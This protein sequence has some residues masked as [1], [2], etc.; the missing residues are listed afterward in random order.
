MGLLK[1]TGTLTLNQFWPSG[2]SDADTAHVAVKVAQNAFKFQ[3]HPGAPFKATHVFDKARVKGKFAPK[4]AIDKQGR[5]T[6]R[7]QGIDAPELH[8]SP[9][10]LTKKEKSQLTSAQLQQFKQLNKKYRQ[11]F[12]ETATVNLH[13]E[14]A[15]T[16]QAEI[17]CSVT[18]AVSDP[19]D[20]FDTY[21]RF[22]GDILVTINR[23]E[24][25]LN[26][27]LVEAGWAFPTF[28]AS[29]SEAEI[30][31]FLTATKI[32]KQKKNHLLKHLKKVVGKFEKTL[33]FRGKGAIFNP[34][35]DIG[36]AL[37]PKLFR[38]LCTYTVY[39]EVGI[40]TGS[41][42]DFLKNR[43][44]DCFLTNDFLTQGTNAAPMH[45]L[46]EFVHTDGKIDKEPQELV[47]REKRSSLIGPDGKLIPIPTEWKLS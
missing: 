15:K 24:V 8:F 9:T 32:G 12:G 11:L 28:Y 39:R 7:F 45:F 44:D 19:Q 40:V 2:Q 20:V 13:Q 27:W 47:F 29:M 3:T 33:V 5:I 21:G 6:V 36:P 26:R 30:E 16:G 10:P 37:M 31:A 4:P 18:T 1:V 46:S 25:N 41:F 14:L 43:P 34:A 23:K 38:R 42:H 22:I 35:A 17:P